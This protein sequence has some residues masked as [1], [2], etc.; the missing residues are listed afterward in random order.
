M[1][2]GGLILMDVL[3]FIYLMNHPVDQRGDT[4]HEEDLCTIL[5]IPPF[6]GT[7][8]DFIQSLG[9]INLLKAIS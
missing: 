9:L 6:V 3:Q 7:E 1:L 2:T 4:V 5:H 8:M